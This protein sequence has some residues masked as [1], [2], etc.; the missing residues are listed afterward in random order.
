MAK[1]AT[2]SM[3]LK[4]YLY[5]AV[6]V[7][8]LIWG[9]GVYAA[10]VDNNAKSIAAIHDGFVRTEQMETINAQFQYI[11]HRMERFEKMYIHET[12]Q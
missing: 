4:D 5:I 11:L 7:G 1:Q 9:G 3:S 6:T 2:S 12:R 10:K 8:V